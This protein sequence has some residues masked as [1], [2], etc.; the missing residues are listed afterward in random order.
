M[1]PLAIVV[2][3]C[4]CTA[5]LFVTIYLCVYLSNIKRYLDDKF[6]LTFKNLRNTLECINIINNKINTINNII[7]KDKE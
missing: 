6:L 4:I 5:L 3:F 1:T 7:V 2:L